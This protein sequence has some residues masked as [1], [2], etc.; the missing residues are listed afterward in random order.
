MSESKS[1]IAYKV[2]NVS[3]R[4]ADPVVTCGHP[5]CTKH[6]SRPK[7]VRI[8]MGL[9]TGDKTLQKAGDVASV[10][11]SISMCNRGWHAYTFAQL[12]ATGYLSSSY[13]VIF[14]VKLSGDILRQRDK[15]CGSR[16]EMLEEL[17]G[18]KL[19]A[20]RAKVA[21]AQTAKREKERLAEQKR[22]AARRAKRAAQ[23]ANSRAREAAQR[24]LNVARRKVRMAYAR[25]LK[26]ALK[27]VKVA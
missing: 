19:A 25:K 5:G 16:I 2:F 17:T 15:V 27:K 22:H 20:L 11:G 10:S 21:A 1:L 6:R 13:K 8:L 26:A 9:C 12:K 18:D 4:A 14:K 7:A 24:R 3:S 23:A